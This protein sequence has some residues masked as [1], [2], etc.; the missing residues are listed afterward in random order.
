MRGTEQTG[1][2]EPYGI[3]VRYPAWSRA[4]TLLPRWSF[5]YDLAYVLTDTAPG[6]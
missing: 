1:V 6:I 3:T 2:A 4:R 5:T